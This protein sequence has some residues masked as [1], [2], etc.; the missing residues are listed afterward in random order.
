MTEEVRTPYPTTIKG[1]IHPRRSY[2]TLISKD[3]M[4]RVAEMMI[5]TPVKIYGEEVG[6]VV[7]AEVIDDIIHYTAK[8]FQSSPTTAKA[9]EE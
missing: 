3:E 1:T 5:G 7:D 9:V 4:P 6:K 2:Y 8:I